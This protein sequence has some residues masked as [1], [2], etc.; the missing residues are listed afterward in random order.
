MESTNIGRT[1]EEIISELTEAVENDLSV[2]EQADAAKIAESVRNEGIPEDFEKD[3]DESSRGNQIDDD[4]DEEKLKDLEVTLSDEEK[5][6]RYKKSLELKK[7]GNEQYKLGNHLESVN[8]YTEAL[9]TCPLKYQN[10]RSIFYANRAASKIS[11]GRNESAI[12]DCTKAIELNEKYIRAYLR[13]AK[14]YETTDKLDESLADYKKVLEFDPG[15]K[16]ALQAPHRLQPLIDERNEKLKTE[17]LGKLK[18]L[19]NVFLRPFGLSTDS[20]QMTQNPDTGGYS[21]NIKNQ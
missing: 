19:G 2:N 1:N 12:E 13:R 18:D 5:E 15:N 14:L 16:D 11:L 3:D 4:I 9:L 21:I 17:M 20:F 10:D 8:I 6:V 7:S